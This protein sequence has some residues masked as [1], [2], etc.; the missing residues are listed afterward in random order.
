MVI[1]LLPPFTV[2]LS[3]VSP[4]C[5]VMTY[6]TETSPLT[7]VHCNDIDVDEIEV[8]DKP[9]TFSGTKIKI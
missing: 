8:D 7:F 9:V 3:L 1:L 4:G 6:S 5:Q 2:V